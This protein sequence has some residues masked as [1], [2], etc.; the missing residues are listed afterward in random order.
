MFWRLAP[1]KK[2]SVLRFARNVTLF[3]PVNKNS[4]TRPVVLKDFAG[5]TKNFRNKRITDSLVS[6]V[7]PPFAALGSGQ[8]IPV[9]F[10][11]LKPKSTKAGVFVLLGLTPAEIIRPFGWL[12]DSEGMRVYLSYVSSQHFDGC[13]RGS[14]IFPTVM[15]LADGMTKADNHV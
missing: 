14:A 9:L 3:S 12:A 6:R 5:N 10:Y 11:S 8:D 13:Q 7:G 1:P 2:I 4:S 15:D